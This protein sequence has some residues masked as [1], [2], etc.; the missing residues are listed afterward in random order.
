MAAPIEKSPKVGT[1]F[2]ANQKHHM[3]HFNQSYQYGKK[4]KPMGK[5]FGLHNKPVFPIWQHLCVLCS[6]A[7]RSVLSEYSNISTSLFVF[8]S[9]TN[10]IT[11]YQSFS[12]RI[13]IFS[14]KWKKFEEKW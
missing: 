8:S 9:N 3:Q 11:D 5:F 1:E 4:S 13:E 6:I 7:F 2:Y 12:A 14:L 10:V